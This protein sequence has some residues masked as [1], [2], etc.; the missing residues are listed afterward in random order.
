MVSFIILWLCLS[1]NRISTKSIQSINYTILLQKLIEKSNT[2][3]NWPNLQSTPF[4]LQSHLNLDIS[5]SI[6]KVLINSN[7]FDFVDRTIHLLRSSVKPRNVASSL[8]TTIESYLYYRPS[9]RTDS[10]PW[11]PYWARMKHVR[12]SSLGRDSR[13]NDTYFI[14]RTNRCQCGSHTDAIPCASRI[15]CLTVKVWR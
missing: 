13:T 11:H 14:S 5:N 1:F 4:P 15:Y 8:L 6:T 9:E 3:W 12:V 10:P 2:M 7:F